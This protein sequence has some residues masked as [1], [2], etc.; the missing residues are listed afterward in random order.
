MVDI[1]ERLKAE[2]KLRRKSEQLALAQQAAGAGFWDW[3]IPAN[4]LQWSDELFRLFGLDPATTTASFDTWLNIIH[5]DDRVI[6]RESIDTAIRD[7]LQVNNE[8]RIILRDGETRWINTL[9][10]TMYDSQGLAPLR[11]MGIC[12]NITDR[13]HF[14]EELLER[15]V[16]L[17]RFNRAAVDRELRMIDLKKQVNELCARAGEPRRYNVDFADDPDD[18]TG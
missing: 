5:P 11:M 18:V 9:G 14:E 15:A 3:D 4:T 12:L 8:Y 16:E 1:T 6:A 17:E 2:I 7:H 10:N 13:K